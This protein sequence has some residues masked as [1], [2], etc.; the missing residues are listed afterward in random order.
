LRENSYA[1]AS[2]AVL[3]IGRMIGGWLRAGKENPLRIEK[4]TRRQ[5]FVLGSQAS[6][7]IW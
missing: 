6:T 1:F 2:R 7:T 3:E 4:G 5:S